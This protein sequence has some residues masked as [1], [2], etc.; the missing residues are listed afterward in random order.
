MSLTIAYSIAREG[1]AASAL[2]T[3]VASRNIASADNP[4]IARKTAH[5]VSDANSGI[6]MTSVIGAV[7]GALLER[8]LGSLSAQN[9]HTA[10]AAALSELGSVV[11]DPQAASSPAATIG[12]LRTALQLAATAPHD[13]TAARGVLEAAKTVAGAVNEMATL[14]DAV[15]HDAQAALGDGA[16]RLET[17]LRDFGAVNEAVVKDTVRRA[18]ISDHIDRRNALLLDIAELIDVR[19]LVRDGNDMMLFLANGTTLFETAPRKISFDGG[20]ALLPTGPGP[21]LYI[22]GTPIGHA[23]GIGGTLGGLLSVR[24]DIALTVGRQADEIARGLIVATAEWDQASVP[25]LPASA[26]LFTYDGG[27]GLPP[28]GIATPG[29][30]AM[31]KVNP[32]VDP[33]AGGVL[34][35]LRDG[36]ITGPDD[37]SY[38]YN[39]NGGAG[40]SDRLRGLLQQMTQAQSFDPDSGLTA[41]GV[42]VLAFATESAGWIEGERSTQSARLETEKVLSER[43]LGAWQ[44]RVGINV[45]AEML[46]LIA[47]QRSYQASS[48][49][50]TAVNEMFDSLLR[51]TG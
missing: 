27:P 23:D 28:T 3:S 20:A 6:R 44:S 12:A 33:D 16:A 21:A 19:P 9:A 7:D 34:A 49:L 24:D 17:L 51:A 8:A 40:F 22:D 47:L 35:R 50:I 48:R 37:P 36:G 43:T 38:I 14:V 31:F 45:D 30:A 41:S 46:T 11:G 39:T 29:L 32:A 2:S 13:E 18:D 1:L 25:S 10:R 26:G 4:N 42:G 5:L 15:R